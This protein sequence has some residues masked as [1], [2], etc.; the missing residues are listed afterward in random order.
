MS[1]TGRTPARFKAAL[2]GACALAAFAAGSA[3]YACTLERMTPWQREQ[4]IDFDRQTGSTKFKAL[5][6]SFTAGSL[7]FC[8]A[9]FAGA[10]AHKIYKHKRGRQ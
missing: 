8:A 10:T 3:Y 1:R 4:K 7:V 2:L 5:I 6:D 9:A